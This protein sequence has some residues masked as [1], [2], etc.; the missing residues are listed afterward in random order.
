MN[1]PR[2][3]F[4]IAGLIAIGIAAGVA[5]IADGPA[6]AAAKSATSTAA[7][8][9]V[10]A[11]TGTIPGPP[12][13]CSAGEAKLDYEWGSYLTG[14]GLTWS[15]VCGNGTWTFNSDDTE[16]YLWAIRMPTSPYYR[17][18]LHQDSNGDGLTACLYSQDNDIYIEDYANYYLNAGFN[19]YYPGNVQVS[20][21]TASC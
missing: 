5:F 7:S 10:P 18:W 1:G 6:Q 3:R 4:I 8:A 21:N 16:Y 9:A 13:T 14:G 17:V 12:Q 19:I 15:D 2:F 11:A 20:D